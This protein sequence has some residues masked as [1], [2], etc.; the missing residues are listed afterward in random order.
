VCI[1]PIFK[2]SGVRIKIL[3]YLA[4]N[5]QVITTRKGIEGIKERK[6]LTIANSIEEFSKN[7]L[8]IIAE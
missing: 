4:C 3:E 6:N 8:K 2:G 7:I 1:A 5:K